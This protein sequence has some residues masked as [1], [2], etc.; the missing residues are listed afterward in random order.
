MS[1]P[2][3]AT[4][5]AASI[6]PEAG[7]HAVSLAP[8]HAEAAQDATRRSWQTYPYYA[9]RYGERGWRFSLSD[10]GWLETLLQLPAGEAI[11]Q[12]RW[13][14]GLLRARGMPSVLLESHLG[15]LAQE[16]AIRGTDSGGILRLVDDLRAERRGRVD[17]PR[18]QALAGSLPDCGAPRAPRNM[19]AV[20][21]SALLDEAEA[22][23][24]T[25][26]IVAWATQSG[27]FDA[28]WL[29]RL[30]AWL[31]AAADSIGARYQGASAAKTPG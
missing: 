3:L 8:G 17:E 20:F 15:F 12:M 2:R 1:T 27:L 24:S 10:S 16:L 9:A 6:N 4:G 28:A 7:T 23:G 29:E 19:G 26:E 21:L 5:S 11:E 30:D 22:P 14:R 13:L 31:R 18:W 25:A